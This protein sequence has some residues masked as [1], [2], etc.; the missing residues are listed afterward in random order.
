MY[1]LEFDELNKDSIFVIQVP[2]HVNINTNISGEMG[3]N[4]DYIPN[5][6]Q[7]DLVDYC[8]KSLL[9][10]LVKFIGNDPMM[11]IDEEEYDY[12]ATYI[13]VSCSS[14]NVES[15]VDKLKAKCRELDG[16]RFEDEEE[17]DLSDEKE[18]PWEDAWDYR[19]DMHYTRDIP[20]RDE[21]DAYDY[22]HAIFS[23]E[24]TFEYDKRNL[25]I[26]RK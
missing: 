25:E 22:Y 16:S 23:V 19:Y 1:F 3:E 6:S 13:T 18:A 9:D 5:Q 2:F 10:P 15:C 11:K 24:V 17:F 8:L 7:E 12:D 4:D 14:E 20:F 21:D 26:Y